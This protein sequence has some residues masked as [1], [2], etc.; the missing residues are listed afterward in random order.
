MDLV[1]PLFVPQ[2]Q[3]GSVFGGYDMNHLE[4]MG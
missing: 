3:T 2:G 1:P 4:I